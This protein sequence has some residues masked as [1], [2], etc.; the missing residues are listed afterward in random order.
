MIRKTASRKQDLSGKSSLGFT[1]IE[2]MISLF[3]LAVGLLGMAALQNEA[4]QYN[5]A[6]FVDSQAQFLLNDMVERIRANSG[7]NTYAINWNEADP[8][9]A[10]NCASV[11][12][13]SNEIADWDVAEWRSKVTDTA[14]LTGGE[15]RI[16]FNN[17]N[18]TFTVEI[19]YDWSQL[20]ETTA[21]GDKRTLS[22][23]TRV[24]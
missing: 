23:T 10:K 6:A 16:L 20:G 1:L 14:Y 24:Q 9:P 22:I 15:S 2:M 17:L 21:L 12:C 5:H 8:V 13:S 4:L 3:I 7:N 18:R 11:S 19:R